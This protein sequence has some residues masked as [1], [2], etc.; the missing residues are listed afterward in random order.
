MTPLHDHARRALTHVTDRS[1]GTPLDPAL[2]V[3]LNFH[4]TFLHRLADEGVYRSQFVTGTGNGGLTARPGGDRW[5]WESRMFGGAYDE[6]PAETRPVYGALDFRR[7]P[8]GA[9]PAS[10]PPICGSRPPPWTGRP[11]ATRTASWSP[12]TSASRPGWA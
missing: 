10:A 11:S 9:A 12:T 1:T 7:R 2:R 5:R 8:Y 3:T 4:P 6:A